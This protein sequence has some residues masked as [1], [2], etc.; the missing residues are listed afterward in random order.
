MIPSSREWAEPGETDGITKKL[1][2]YYFQGQVVRD[3]DFSFALLL[4]SHLLML[5]NLAAML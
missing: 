3:C 1:T 5:M 4:S 2:G